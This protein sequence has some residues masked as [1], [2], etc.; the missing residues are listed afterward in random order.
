MIWL[1]ILLICLIFLG[2]F[3]TLFNREIVEWYIKKFVKSGKTET[4]K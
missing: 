1:E 2:I 4:I 3:I